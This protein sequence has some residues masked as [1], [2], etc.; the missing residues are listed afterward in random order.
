[1][2]RVV[3]SVTSDF[4]DALRVEKIVAKE[5][6]GATRYNQISKGLGRPAPITSIFIEGELIFEQTP[7]TQELKTCIQRFVSS[8][9]GKS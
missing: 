6:Q 5:L 1:M 8:A 4:D 9:G 7:G 3:E 2:A